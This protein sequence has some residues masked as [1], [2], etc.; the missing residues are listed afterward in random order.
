MNVWPHI[1]LSISVAMWLLY[2]GVCIA[3]DDLLQQGSVIYQ[4]RCA[5]CHGKTGEGVAKHY[6]KPLVGDASIEELAELITDTMPKE[7]SETCVGQESLAVAKYIHKAFYNKSAQQP[8]IKLARLTGTQLRQSLADLYQHFSGVTGFSEKHGLRAEYYDSSRP[9]R[10]KRKIERID[11]SIDFDFQDKGPGEGINAGDFSI[12]WTGGLKVDVTGQYELI[13]RST[14]AFV[15]YFGSHSRELINNHVQSGDKTE[16]RHSMALTGGRVYPLKL[17]LYQRKRKTG[18]PPAR[19]SLSW[20]PPHATE[21]IVPSRNLLSEPI[22]ATFALQ[23]KLPPDDRS[24]G[25]ERGIAVDRQW[26]DSTTAAAIEF[27]EVAAEEL[28]PRYRSG[29]RNVSDQNRARL[30]SFLA[31]LVETAF[32]G[33]IDDPLRKLY[34][35]DPVDASEDDAEAIRR[36]VLITLKSPRFLYPL[37]DQDRSYSQRV[38]NRLA[39]VLHDSLPSDPWLLQ[40]VRNDKLQT[41]SELRSAARRMA[42]DFRTRGK[43]R[44]MIYAWLNLSH[45]GEINKDAEAFP[46]FDAALVSDLRASFDALIDDIVWSDV[47]DFRQLL[48]A[49]WTFTNDRLFQ[50][51]GDTWQPSAEGAGLQRSVAATDRHAGLLTHPYLMSGLAYPDSTSPIHRGVFV[52]RYL[53]GRTLRPPQEAFTPLSPDLHPDLTTRERIALQTSPESCQVCHAK[54]NALGFTLENFDAVG[55]YRVKEKDREIDATGAYTTL[56]GQQTKIDGPLELSKFLASSDDGHRAFVE[57]AFEHFVKQPVA[58]YGADTLNRLTASFRENNFNMRD[59]L[60]E[61]AVIAARLPEN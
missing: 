3:D 21:Q 56:S 43:T 61:I 15:C 42:N 20:N 60:V 29:R 9:R 50:Y 1:T 53:L 58:A 47:S 8:R 33:P 55:R 10:D 2:S 54:I 22:P 32:R 28:W 17:E 49:D 52:I 13:I 30:R 34:V 41:E 26:D 6:D 36:S 16:F 7:D 37:L 11:P 31:E 35:D 24:Y 27:S 39:L 18:Q 40:Q 12:Q 19:V 4:S 38:A 48:R 57:R 44:E 59:L 14:C 51:Y 46:G 25:Y 5:N 23:A 45:I